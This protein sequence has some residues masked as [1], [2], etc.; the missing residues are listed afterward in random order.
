ME[1]V[2]ADIKH[3]KPKRLSLKEFLQNESGI[4]TMLSFSTYLSLFFI[5]LM[6]FKSAN[7]NFVL[8]VFVIFIILCFTALTL[9]LHQEIKDDKEAII[10]NEKN[11]DYLLSLGVE[12][13]SFYGDAVKSSKA[14]NNVG[15]MDFVKYVATTIEID[16]EEFIK[17]DKNDEKW[18]KS[19]YE[20]LNPN[21]SGQGVYDVSD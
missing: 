9:Y 8:F 7:N 5:I 14:K 1:F 4:M 19:L 2:S 20:K 11:K 12:V 16:S 18:V 6:S 10:P 17:G 21:N 15:I 13:K 3:F